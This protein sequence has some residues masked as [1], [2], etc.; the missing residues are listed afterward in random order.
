MHVIS[1]REVTFACWGHLAQQKNHALQHLL[2]PT[3]FATLACRQIG[4]RQVH[5]ARSSPAASAWIAFAGV[6]TNPSAEVAIGHQLRRILARKPDVQGS[7]GR[8]GTERSAPWP[9]FGFG[10]H[11]WL[12]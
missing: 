10:E 11:N 6:G 2:L 7:N 9:L 8:G 5:F 4:G 1:P 3:F 12:A